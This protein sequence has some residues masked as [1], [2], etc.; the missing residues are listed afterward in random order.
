MRHTKTHLSQLALSIVAIVLLSALSSGIKVFAEEIKN[1][2]F[3]KKF[4]VRLSTYNVTDADT[5]ITV[6]GSSGIGTSVNFDKDLGGDNTVTVPRIDAYYR[7]NEYHRIDFSNFRTDRDGR[8]TIDTD[9]NLGDQSFAVGDTV[10]SQ[11]KFSLTRIG[12][13]YSFYHSPEVELTLTAGLNINRYDFKYKLASGGSSS[14]SDAGGP[15]PTFGLRLAYKISPKWS[16]RY[17]SETFFIDID[18][19]FKGTLLNY[20][21]NIE[22]RFDNQLVLGAGIARTSTDLEVDDSD[23]KGR[24][25]DS[26]RGLMLSAG[27]YF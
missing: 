20:E 2:A 17:A 15:L 24:L 8:E 14:S 7:F 23:W 3:P 5:D 19:T 12:Y 13:G 4:M 21:L 9:I 26:N 27:Y 6:F 18:D 16:V 1:V 10:E 25:S 11:I 22:Y